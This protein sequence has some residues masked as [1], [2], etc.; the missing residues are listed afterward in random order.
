MKRAMVLAEWALLGLLVAFIS[1]TLVS[2][3]EALQ[4]G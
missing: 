1:I 2:T 4:M 3:V